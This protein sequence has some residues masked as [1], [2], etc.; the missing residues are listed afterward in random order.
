MAAQESTNRVQTRQRQP[1]QGAGELSQARLS[2]EEWEAIWRR[3]WRRIR[4]WRVPPRWNSLDWWDEARA[5]G[6]LAACA[7]ALEFDPTRGVP[8]AS[9]LYQ[10]TLAGVWTWHRQE[11][12]YGRHL[13]APRSLDDWPA[14]GAS[15]SGMDPVE[16]ASCLDQLG[17]RDRWLIWQLFWAGTTEATLAAVLGISHQ[18][19]SQRKYH[20]LKR[21]RRGT[22]LF[23]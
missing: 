23:R 11:W 10:R 17:I 13:R 19:V 5:E 7:A 12:A 3:C 15:A 20:V 16:V 2:L 8:R 1:F 22:S 21:L 6:A 18:A 9:F 4:S 14:A